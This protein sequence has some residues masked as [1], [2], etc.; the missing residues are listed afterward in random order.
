MTV[1]DEDWIE[2]PVKRLDR[3]E[4]SLA[5]GIK[6]QAIMQTEMSAQRQAIEAIQRTLNGMASDE[7]ADLKRRADLP[8]RILRAVLVPVLVAVITAVV[9]ALVAGVHPF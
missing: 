4:K 5:Q 2:R 3:L 1:E 7:I 9:G 8:G 6:D